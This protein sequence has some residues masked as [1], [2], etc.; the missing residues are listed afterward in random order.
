MSQK[1]TERLKG[2]GHVPGLYCH[3]HRDWQETEVCLEMSQPTLRF[4]EL[5]LK[6]R[7]PGIGMMSSRSQAHLVTHWI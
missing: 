1:G 7:R 4:F 6:N 3:C 5:L 2:D